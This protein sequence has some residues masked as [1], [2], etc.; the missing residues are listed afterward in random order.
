MV[1]WGG[2]LLVT[3]IVFSL[4]EG[5]IH[6]YY[7]VALAP[8]IGALAGIGGV[9][10]WNRRHEI[11][12]R[13]VLAG[14]IA[15]TALWARELL[16]RVPSWHP[17]LRALVVV[18]GLALAAAVLWLPR[19]PARA[20]LA[21]VGAAAVVG[22]AAPAAYT[23]STV[24]TPHTGAI[25]IAGPAGA[26]GRFGPGGGRG[27][28]PGGLAGGQAP[29]LGQEPGGLIP[30]LGQGP[31]ALVP[32]LGDG[33]GFR[34]PGGGQGMPNVGG[35]PG[36]GG[37]GGGAVGGLLDAGEPSAEITSLLQA[38]G[39]G[40]RWTAAAVGANS[41]AGFQL[42][43]GE[44]IMAI[45]G[46]NGSDPAPSLEQFRSHV[47][48]GDIHYFIGGGGL[49]GGFG[50]L[51]GPGG[52]GGLGGARGGSNASSE[53]SAWVSEHF[54]AETVGGVTIYDLSAGAAGAT[55]TGA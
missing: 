8:A 23:L 20:A 37:P 29:N 17:E 50:G 25:P 42:A 16:Q 53:I 27:G 6:E 13:I 34:I 21:V 7:T 1:L 33:G 11:A 45:G 24:N 39:D 2:W 40:Y 26:G 5:I 32:N 43:S 54:E 28:G 14:A 3:G 46:F 35:G 55:A 31:G 18:G 51:G 4:G 44:P 47:A 12:A 9:T 41:A 15:V 38:G 36:G 49:A 10:L 52:F 30:N 22:L 48:N 19:F